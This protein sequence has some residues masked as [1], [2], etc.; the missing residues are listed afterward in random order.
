MTRV[1]IIYFSATGATHRMAEAAAEG[2]GAVA[3]A[4]LVRI[5]GK[6]II[7]GRFRGAAALAAADIADAVI[8]GS[9][10]FMGGPAAE[11]KAFADAT[12]D[13]WDTQAWSGK[14]AGGFTSGGYPNGDQGA[15][16]IFLAHLAAQHGMLW[17]PPGLSGTADPAG[18]NRFGASLGV[19]GLGTRDRVEDADLAAARHLGRRVA[20]MAARLAS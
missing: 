10:T 2:A 3:G 19:T 6:D 9:P 5:S 18:L 13:R 8:F 7:E 16:L 17:C 20:E 1:A 14:I 4:A 12:S 15:T 11:F